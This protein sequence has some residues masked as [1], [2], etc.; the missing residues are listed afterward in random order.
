MLRFHLL[1]SLSRNEC[2]T[3]N[4]HA[5]MSALVTCTLPLTDLMKVRPDLWESVA[6]CL[7]EQGLWNKKLPMEEILTPAAVESIPSTKIKVPVNRT[8]G[9]GEDN[10]GN[11]TLPVMINKVESIVILDN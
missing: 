1:G 3:A 9:K 11:T 2:D 4:L 6:R 5:L 7:T 10:K 8:R